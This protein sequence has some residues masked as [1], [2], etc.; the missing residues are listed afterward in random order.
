LTS[1]EA[2][3]PA[4]VPAW[5]AAGFP[6]TITSYQPWASST[7][8]G[9]ATQLTRRFANGLQGVLAYTYSH[10]IDDATAEVFSTVLAPRRA[11]DSQDLSADR[12]NSILDHRHRLT[13]T[14]I[15]DEPF[16]KN[17]NFFLK[18]TLGNWEIAPIYTYQSGQWVTPQSGID[19][20]LNGDAAPD[21]VIFNAAGA[22][23]TGT[24]VTGLCHS[25]IPSVDTAGNAI[26]TVSNARS[27]AV[28]DGNNAAG[29]MPGTPG[30]IYYDVR[31][32]IVGYQAT[33]PNARFVQAGYGALA[34]VGRS[35]LQLAPINDIDLT[36]LKRFT[37]TERFKVEFQ[38]QAFNLFNHPQYVGGFINDI[39]PLGF[40][41]SQRNVLI[42][43]D[44]SF[45]TP[46]TQFVSN[47]RT[48]Q[49]ALKLYF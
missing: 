8:H 6:N 4:V 16:F 20:N 23:G 24:G 22:S 15:Y 39:A 34:N 1:L 28:G 38:A 40:T 26:C 45:N 46:S 31:D 25:V 37:I 36:A 41:G 2:A 48:L 29:C 35:T 13:L 27:T 3:V 42:P 19:S 7:Y 47:A 9:L 17:S 14:M 43:G 44:A 10:N 30:C 32:N 18:N 5:S 21:R 49:L 11:Q 12:A 33:N